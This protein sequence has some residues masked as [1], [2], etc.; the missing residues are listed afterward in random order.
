VR[1]CQT[2]SMEGQLALETE[3]KTYADHLVEL[4]PQAGKFVLIRGAEVVGTFDTYADAL[5][6]GYTK[7]QLE[8]FLVKQIAPAERVMSFSRDHEFVYAGNH[9]NN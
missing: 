3:L 9:P 2:Q 4:I 1:R 6:A 7:F 5:K 8:P